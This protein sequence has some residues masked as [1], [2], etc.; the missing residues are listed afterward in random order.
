MIFFSFRREA[1]EC[2]PRRPASN[3]FSCKVRLALL[4]ITHY[5]NFFFNKSLQKIEG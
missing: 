5:L 2:L 1:A 3:F 4:I